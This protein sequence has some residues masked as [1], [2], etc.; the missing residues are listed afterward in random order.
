MAELK[1]I[2][3]HTW[4]GETAHYLYDKFCHNEI[5][6]DEIIQKWKDELGGEESTEVETIPTSWKPH[7]S[8]DKEFV[9]VFE[10]EY[11]DLYKNTV[12]F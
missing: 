12:K 9:V 11:C 8:S 3:I 1:G 4:E 10:D 6:V 5:T 2:H 7:I